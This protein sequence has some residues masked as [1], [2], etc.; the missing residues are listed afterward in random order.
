MSIMTLNIQNESRYISALL[1][2]IGITL[3]LF[4]IM[5]ALIDSGDQEYRADSDGQIME[6]VRIKDDESLS[7]KD[8]RKPVKPQPPKEPPPP[9]KLVV[10]KEAKPTMNKTATIITL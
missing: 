4:F 2:G 3:I 5:Q 1:I 7:F 8:R 9:P 6:F 10:Q